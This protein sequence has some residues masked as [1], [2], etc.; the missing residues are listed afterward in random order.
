MLGIQ[1]QA[2]IDSSHSIIWFILHRFCTEP[3]NFGI[4]LEN[5][6]FQKIIKMKYLSNES[7]SPT[8][9]FLGENLFWKDQTAFWPRKL[10]LKMKNLEFLRALRKIWLREGPVKRYETFKSEAKVESCTLD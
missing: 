10:I 8:L 5:K 4:F 2:M 3:S 9:I 6:V 1:T 7:C